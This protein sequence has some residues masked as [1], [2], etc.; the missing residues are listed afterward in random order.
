[1]M[2]N[3]GRHISKLWVM[4]VVW[5]S[6]LEEVG[7]IKLGDL[8]SRH[9]GAVEPNPIIKS[10]ETIKFLVPRI[11]AAIWQSILAPAGLHRGITPTG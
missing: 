4:S 11:E 6:M 7:P 8:S 10:D 9:L 3:K 1:M 2:N 5:S